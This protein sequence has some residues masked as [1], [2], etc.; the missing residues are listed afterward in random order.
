[1]IPLSFSLL[2]LLTGAG[3]HHP[4]A[5]LAADPG[6]ADAFL[7]QLAAGAPSLAER[8]ERLSAAFV[9]APYLDSPLGED[10]GVDADPR[11]RLDAVDCL[12][13]VEQAIALSFASGELGRAFTLLQALRYSGSQY[14][15][16]ERL[17]LM[18]SQW[19]PT[20]A[21]RGIVRDIT[22]Q[23][24]GSAVRLASAHLDAARFSARRIAKDLALPASALPSG[25]FS[26]PVIPLERLAEVQ[27]KIPPAT[28]LSLVR[29]DRPWAPDLVTHVGLLFPAGVP[30]KRGAPILRHASRLA[31]RV[32][33]QPLPQFIARVEE[34]SV[35]PVDGVNLLEIREPG[36]R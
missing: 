15:F 33:D 6:G 17:H 28:I 23:V 29:K 32:I 25:D 19:I 14:R 5:T 16:E 18:M 2:S 10:A 34:T 8:L 12:T 20:Q 26:L 1:M 22:R 31:K 36:P 11:M 9:G 7:R 27:D 35:W 4:L 24:G 13:L 21:R 3:A 30:E